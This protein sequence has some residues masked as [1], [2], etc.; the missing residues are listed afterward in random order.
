MDKEQ[1]TKQL[2][3]AGIEYDGRLGAEKL[4]ELLP[5]A[6]EKKPDTVECVVLRDFWDEDGERWKKGRIIHIAPMDAIEGIEKG[7]IK[8]L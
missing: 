4:A 3:D 7:S 1:I 6:P 8:R 5:V 2:D